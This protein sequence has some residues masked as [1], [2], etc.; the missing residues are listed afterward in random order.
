MTA[1]WS[2]AVLIAS[3]VLSSF[4]AFLFK[5][6]SKELRFHLSSVL[7]KELIIGVGLYGISTILTLIAY[8]GGE[9]TVLVPLGSLNY[10][11]AA[12]LAQWFLGEQMNTWKWR[13]V[14]FIIC[15]IALIGIG[16]V[17]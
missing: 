13:G 9:L 10:L 1:P 4:A 6:A 8:R 11:W 3:T 14:A 2:I 15:G 7:N 12:F 17:L 16:G 5:V